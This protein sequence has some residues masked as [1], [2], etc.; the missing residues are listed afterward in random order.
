MILPFISPPLEIQANTGRPVLIETETLSIMGYRPDCAA[1]IGMIV[2]DVF[3]IDYGL[4]DGIA[5][6]SRGG[7]LVEGEEAW[8]DGWRRRTRAEW[9]ALSQKYGVRVV[10]A[11][12]EMLLHL[13]LEWTGS[14]WQ[15]YVIP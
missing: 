15:L 13:P 12:K 7:R 1:S 9:Q 4:P 3:D 11:P 2:R 14:R 10:L 8:G 5:A 6:M